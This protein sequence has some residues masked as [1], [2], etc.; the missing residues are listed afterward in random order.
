MGSLLLESTGLSRGSLVD[1]DILYLKWRGAAN[2][3]SAGEGDDR[4][5]RTNRAAHC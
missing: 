1:N 3:L 4:S 2:S 5:E